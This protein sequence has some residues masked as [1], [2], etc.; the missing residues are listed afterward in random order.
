M[1]EIKFSRHSEEKINLLSS[2]EL[3]ITKQLV[4]DAVS[5]PDK[6]E[7]KGQDKKIAQKK[8]NQNLVIRVVYQEFTAFILII[9]VY[10]G[11]KKRYEKN[12]I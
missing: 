7:E 5:N 12:N 3:I 10:P 1:K 8:L 2:H 4:V 9:T 11:R 6:I